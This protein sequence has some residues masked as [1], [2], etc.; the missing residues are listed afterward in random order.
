MKIKRLN[1][2]ITLVITIIVLLIL[3]GVTIS[4]LTG[5]NGLLSKAFNAKTKMTEAE[6]IEKV[7]V[8]VLASYDENGSLD[9]D[10]LNENLESIEGLALNE[11]NKIK[12]FPGA[13]KVNN[14]YIIINSNGEVRIASENLAKIITNPTQYYG[15]EVINYKSN[16]NDT[17]IYRIFYVDNENYFGDGIN[18]VYL[19]AD[20][21]DK[22]A[23]SITYDSSKTLIRKMNP[24]WASKRGNNENSW[25][26]NEKTSAWLCDPSN[27]TQYLNNDKANYAIGGPS[28]EMYVKSYNQAYE[29]YIDD[30]D[31]YTLGTVYSETNSPGYIFTLDGEESNLSNGNFYTTG[32]NSIDYKKYNSMYCGKN[33]KISGWWWWIASPNAGYLLWVCISHEANG[34]S[35]SGYWGSS[36]VSPLI[37]LKSD[38][39][40]EFGEEN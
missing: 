16:E 10:K 39:E 9:K 36:Y 28:I 1:N 4:T 5:D 3:T 18:S 20:Y 33:G 17:N 15:K 26:N 25:K 13:I 14:N 37:S 34:L 27:W 11:E 30:N 23:G 24:L 12:D 35:E 32:V 22:I 21:N 29:E 19:K 38:F 31:I 40:P 8:E 7:K 6:L 2:G